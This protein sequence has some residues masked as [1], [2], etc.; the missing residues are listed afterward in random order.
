MATK[1]HSALE[2]S[3]ILCVFT[4]QDLWEG[5]PEGSNINFLTPGE[6]TSSL[7]S[8]TCLGSS[9][10]NKAMS[11]PQLA[12]VQA[13]LGTDVNRPQAQLSW[14]ILANE[15]HLLMSQ[16]SDSTLKLSSSAQPCT[17]MAFSPCLGSVLRRSLPVP[18]ALHWL[19]LDLCVPQGVPFLPQCMKPRKVHFVGPL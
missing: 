5:H 16:N 14:M 10:S 7:L 15:P 17:S 19:F 18:A 11:G 2:F 9:H 8:G 6:K 3:R 12:A 1:A 4:R 13:V